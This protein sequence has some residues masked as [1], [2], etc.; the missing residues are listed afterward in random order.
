M[1]QGFKRNIERHTQ[2]KRKQKV[3]D[4]LDIVCYHID[5]RCGTEKGSTLQLHIRLSLEE[6]VLGTQ[7]TSIY[8]GRW[9]LFVSTNCHHTATVWETGDLIHYWNKSPFSDSSVE[10]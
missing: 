1:V 3:L 10:V 9:G 4:R 7:R 6:R 2:S 5:I 8:A